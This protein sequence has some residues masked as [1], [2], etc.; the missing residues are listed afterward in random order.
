MSHSNRRLK[1]HKFR[2]SFV[3]TQVNFWNI[4]Q[5]N[6]DFTARTI[7]AVRKMSLKIHGHTPWLAFFSFLFL[8][9]P[10]FLFWIDFLKTTRRCRNVRRRRVIFPDRL[11]SH[12]RAWMNSKRT[13]LP[14]EPLFAGITDEDPSAMQVHVLE[15]ETTQDTHTARSIQVN[16]W[17]VIRAVE[18]LKYIFT[19]NWG[20]NFIK[21]EE[22]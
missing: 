18:K 21:T 14:F 22:I 13:F 10:T 1:F 6:W 4:N 9:D 3:Q 15:I 11:G 7:R 12:C 20:S 17:Q 16:K 19:K 2:T 8:L 5:K